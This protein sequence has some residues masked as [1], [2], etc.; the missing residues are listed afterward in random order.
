MNWESALFSQGFGTRYDCRALILNGL[1]SSEGSVIEDPEEEADLVGKR[2]TVRGE[3]WPFC[4]HALVVLNKP[5]GYECSM[6]P[7]GYPSVLGLMPA[8]LRARNIQPVGRLDA[9]TTGLLLLTDDGSL[10]HR[11]THPK[12]H[13]AK[14]YRVVVKHALTTKDAERLIAGVRL[15]DEPQPICAEDC[16][17]VDERTLLLTITSGK[18]HQVKR[19]IAAI[20]NRVEQLH[21]VA[22]GRYRLPEDLPL[23]QWRW[24]ES[25][26]VG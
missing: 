14:V 17:L 26:E 16:T 22:F 13:V 12:R 9:D 3:E 11:W 4:E 25:D 15:N 6:K 19:M 21:R 8:P 2:F 1:V 5:A 10:I 24:I 7:S 23:G 20:G 18:Y